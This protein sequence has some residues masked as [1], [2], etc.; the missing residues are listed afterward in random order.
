M[1][2]DPE[3]GRYRPITQ[4]KKARQHEVARLEADNWRD[5]H[6]GVY[7]VTDRA[8]GPTEQAPR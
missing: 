6:Q 2:P 1:T 4:A 3:E 8:V 7:R 5:T